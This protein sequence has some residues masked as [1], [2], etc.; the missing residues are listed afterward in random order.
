MPVLTKPPLNL[1]REIF[2]VERILRAVC[3]SPA[4]RVRSAGATVDLDRFIDDRGILILDGSSQ[5]NLSRDATSIMMGAIALRVQTKMF[6][7]D[8]IHDHASGKRIIAACDCFRHFE[9]ATSFLKWFSIRASDDSQELPQ[10][11][12]GHTDQCSDVGR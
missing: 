9:P 3:E 7:P 2:H 4:F 12:R 1:D 10:H 11:P 6:E 5:G 8:A